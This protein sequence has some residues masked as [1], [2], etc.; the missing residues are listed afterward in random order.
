MRLLALSLAVAAN[1]AMASGTTYWS[2][3]QVYIGDADQGCAPLGRMLK[4]SEIEATSLKYGDDFCQAF[5]H[6]GQPLRYQIDGEDGKT[7]I[8]NGSLAGCSIEEIAKSNEDSQ[9]TPRA[10]CI[11]EQ[12]PMGTAYLFQN[13]NY[14][15]ITS[16]GQ[17]SVGWSARPKIVSSGMES[18][19]DH[20]GS[21]RLANGVKLEA[22]RRPGF[23]GP[24]REYIGNIENA[25]TRSWRTESIYPARLLPTSALYYGRSFYRDDDRKAYDFIL[26]QIG[27]WE[28]NAQQIGKP[29]PLKTIDFSQ[30]DFK[31]QR[32]TLK[33][34]LMYI[35]ADV[36]YI[37]TQF[38]P[39]RNVKTDANGNVLSM[40]YRSHITPSFAEY[41]DE[42]KLIEQRAASILTGIKPDM[43][44]AQKVRLLHDVLLANVHYGMSTPG[45]DDLRGAF[46]HNAVLC[47]GYARGLVY[48]LQ[49]AD[50][51]AIYITGQT[52][53]GLHAWVKAKV[54]GQWYN[55]DPT[56]NDGMTGNSLHHTYFLKADVNFTDHI[57]DQGTYYAPL[58]TKDL[59]TED[60]PLAETEYRATEIE[61]EEKA[62][63]VLYSDRD[64]QG[65]ALHITEDMSYVGDDINDK[66]SSFSIPEGWTVRFFEGSDY[67]GGYYTR[68]ANDN[69]HNFAQ[70]FNDK[71]S[72]VKIVSKP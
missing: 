47:E 31:I 7:W 30:Q 16:I 61:K 51:P 17:E 33:Q 20:I 9:V 1:V 46:I 53:Q 70:G 6:D 60:Y 62:A 23:I 29:Q 45:T 55:I 21:A 15:K 44:T 3:Y 14:A 42:I 22:Y 66:M 65:F 32:E 12:P 10:A 58:P 8:F 56:W 54:D 13:R 27:T 71:I 59:A 50:I 4:K 34:M 64:H 35:R 68:T 39:A 24:V 52:S 38:P 72:S 26:D 28:D 25:N 43:T 2:A 49:L 36:Q 40:D 67:Q 19:K 69:D 18:A 11:A 5:I 48:L 37:Y 41:Q 63:I 57:P